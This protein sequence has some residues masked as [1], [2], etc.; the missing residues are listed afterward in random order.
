MTIIQE[1]NMLMWLS[2]EAEDLFK[3]GEEASLRK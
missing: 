2:M 3:V 1:I